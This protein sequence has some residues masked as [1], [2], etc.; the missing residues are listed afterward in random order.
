M[1]TIKSLWNHDTD[2]DYYYYEIH[3]SRIKEYCTFD[4]KHM[5]QNKNKWI[6][7]KN[8]GD[9][10][11]FIKYHKSIY[12]I[13]EQEELDNIYLNLKIDDKIL[14]YLKENEN[15]K[16]PTDKIIIK[17]V[18]FNEHKTYLFK[19]DTLNPDKIGHFYCTLKNNEAKIFWS[20]VI[21]YT[22]HN[23]YSIKEH[24]LKYKN[25]WNYLFYKKGI[26]L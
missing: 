23:F 18:L 4:L 12:R 1:I 8:D 26:K 19:T 15:L 25:D 6:K 10:Q 3:D 21:G 16:H 13:L 22:A 20:K 17:C 5:K 14:L 7:G 11:Y 9:Y 2:N 24:N